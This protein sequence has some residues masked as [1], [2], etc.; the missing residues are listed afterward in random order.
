MTPELRQ[1]IVHARTG[2]YTAIMR[3]TVFTF[4][5]IAA[6]VHFG[7]DTLSLPL[8][9]LTATIT[10]FGVLAGNTALDDINNLK[11]DMTPEF[12]ETSYG[13]GVVSRDI[14]TLKLISAV[15]ISLT[16]LALILAILF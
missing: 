8:L 13:T 14:P 2:E 16:G 10:A 6:I 3:T 7:P 15:L 1:T 11:S 12:E 9:L 4:T 5:G